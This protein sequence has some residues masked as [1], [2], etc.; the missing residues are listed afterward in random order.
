[1]ATPRR[2]EPPKKMGF[3]GFVFLLGIIAGM[4]WLGMLIFQLGPYRSEEVPVMTTPTNPIPL[5]PTHT[6]RLWMTE[7]PAVPTSTITQTLMPTIT[8]TP[9]P[10][11]LPF[12]L[13]GEPEPMSSAVI[14][15][16]LDCDWLVIAGQVWDLQGEAAT[17]S[18]S[19]HLFGE[20]NG[21]AVDEFR[22]PGAEKAYGESGYE[23]A[24]EGFVVDSEDSLYIQLV[25][26]NNV[27][28]SNPY[29]LQ[30]FNDCQMNL[31]L[32]NFKQVR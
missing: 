6:P 9:T 14:R 19:V 25:D 20:L 23:F 29:L 17:D 13:F 3:M 1:M 5:I 15:P 11:I 28:L 32:V 18:V 7:E 27:P 2:P 4:V 26:A 22:H 21:F 10:K 16:Q 31:I 30:T 24:L 8:V 12:I